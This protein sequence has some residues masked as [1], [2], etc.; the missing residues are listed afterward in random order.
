MTSQD[1]E[2]DMDPNANLYVPFGVQSIKL[3]SDSP[4]GGY[5]RVAFEGHATGPIPVSCTSN[6]LKNALESLP[7]IGMLSFSR[8]TI[9]HMH[10]WLLTFLSNGV[11]NGLVILT[12]LL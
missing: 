8:N 1:L 7:T 6:E 10:V 4:V 11:T 12:K 5:F 9:G 3:S 2:N